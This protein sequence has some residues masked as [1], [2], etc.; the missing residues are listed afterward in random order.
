MKPTLWTVD[1]ATGATGARVAGRPWEASGVAI[2]SRAVAEGDLFVAL[3]GERVDG[4]DYVAAALAKG[5]AAALVE[6]APKGLASDAPLLIVEDVLR[7]L[8]ALATEARS[9][10]SAKVVGVTGSVG[11]T[12]TKEALLCALSAAGETYA[13][14]G[15]LNNHIGA[16]L[17]L[18]R[19][20]R[21]AAYAVLEMGMNHPGEIAPLS[22]MVR[23]HVAIVTNVEPVHIEFFESEVDIAL[24]KAE[25]FEGMEPGGIA[26]LNLDNPWFTT[27]R[28]RA[29]ACGVDRVL[30]FGR[31]AGAEV[32]LIDV[33]SGI[34]GSLVE[35]CVAGRVIRYQL[36]AVGAHWAFNSIG[37][38][39]C[40]H[41]LGLD[42]EASAAAI[43]RVSAGRGRGGQVMVTLAFD[44]SLRLIDESYNASPAAMRAAFSVLNLS[45]P[46]DEG[47]RIAVLGDMRELGTRGTD[48]HAGLADDLLAAVPDKVFTVGPLMRALRA[49]LPRDLRGV[50]GDV[51]TEIADQIAS[52]LRSGDVVLVKG[53]LGTNMA[54]IIAAI[55]ALAEPRRLVV[56]GR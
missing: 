5:A 28:E 7:A 13:S 25:I 14:H 29:R 43:R 1:E 18:S 47:R 16:P 21:E 11:K 52:E 48:L 6:R 39:A 17:S 26:V 44:G 54:P 33:Q 32:R 45:Q 55:E 19:L 56:N 38:L 40:A 3:P 51:S 24:A 49:R 53:S 34:D 15:N 41:A 30:G 4:H 12:G 31:E 2:D 46:V 8:A 36:D 23:P 10:S 27:L 37:V 35:A 20:P 22:A 42:V 50:H 9:R